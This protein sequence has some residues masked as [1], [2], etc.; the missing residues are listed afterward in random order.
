MILIFSDYVPVCVTSLNNYELN[1]LEMQFSPA[2]E[3][4]RKVI[5]QGTLEVKT[6]K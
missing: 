6:Q 2:D 5:R 4:Y 1:M 3:E